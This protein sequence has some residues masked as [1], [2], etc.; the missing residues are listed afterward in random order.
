MEIQV[1][2]SIRPGAHEQP[3]FGLNLPRLDTSPDRTNVALHPTRDVDVGD[4]LGAAS[5]QHGYL[6]SSHP[7][8]RHHPISQPIQSAAG[9]AF[10]EVLQTAKEGLARLMDTLVFN[11]ESGHLAEAWRRTG[12]YLDLVSRGFSKRLFLVRVHLF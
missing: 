5:C 3:S 7:Q 2:L 6:P 1:L 10:V 8:A 12:V 11:C 9:A 4:E